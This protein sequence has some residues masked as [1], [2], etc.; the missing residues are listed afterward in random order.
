MWFDKK[1][2]TVFKLYFNVETAS[3]SVSEN[4]DEK[5]IAVLA[6]DMK[7]KNPTEAIVLEIVLE[8]DGEIVYQDDQSVSARVQL[9]A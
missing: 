8:K 4:C 1:E 6:A 2:K 3:G 9:L 5:G 7:A